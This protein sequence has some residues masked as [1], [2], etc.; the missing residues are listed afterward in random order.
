MRSAHFL[1]RPR[2]AHRADVATSHAA[3]RNVLHVG[4]GGLIDDDHET[5]KLLAAAANYSLHSQLAK[6]A[7]NLT[8]MDINPRAIEIMK[9][10]VPGR[11]IAADVMSTSLADQCDNDLFEVI[12]FGDVIEHLDN[13][14]TA[15]RNLTTL[16]AP[17]GYIVIS[18]VNA[19]S[20]GTFVKMAFRYELTHPE[21]TCYF[22][23]LTLKRTLE[24]NGLDMLDVIFCTDKH[25]VQFDSWMYR[26][27]HHV[28]NVVALILPQ[29][30][31]GIVVIA[32]PSSVS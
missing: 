15:L 2:L 23:Y 32:S 29:F 14:G 12:I 4:M 20:F 11:Y 18:T 10:A 13:F 28:S 24:M 5:E 25:S 19:F 9:R 6:V 22:S 1:P 16:L 8:G 26:V 7:A 30:A 21:H 17:N 27:D 31:K 3:G